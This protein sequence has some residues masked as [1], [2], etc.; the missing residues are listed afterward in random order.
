MRFTNVDGGSGGTARLSLRYVRQYGGGTAYLRVN[1]ASQTL[2][3]LRQDP[4]MAWNTG[5]WRWLTLDVPLNAGATNTIEV[6]RGNGDL[7]LNGLLV[8][9]ASQLV[10]AQP[11]RLVQSLPSGD[12]SDL[13]DYLTQLDGRD[14]NGVA[15]APPT[16]PSPQAPGIVSEPQSLTLA[17]GNALNFVVAVSGTGPFTY[18]W[19]RGTTIIGTN[20]PELQIA[21]VS[22]A[23]AG[24]YTC[25]V[26]NAQGSAVTTPAVNASAALRPRLIAASMIAMLLGPGLA[27]AIT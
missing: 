15:L 16:T 11:H 23:D 4:D 10:I 5:G 1:G 18:E 3:T 14:A 22:L 12:R 24:S 6:L 13:I 27:A 9:N 25:T 26:T 7:I 21:S 17:E 8:S 2:T 20:S 19:R